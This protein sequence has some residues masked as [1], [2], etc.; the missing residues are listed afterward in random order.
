MIV[1]R[2]DMMTSGLLIVAKTAEAYHHLQDQFTARTVKKKYLALVEGTPRSE[3]GVI[4]LP[5]SSDPMNRPLQI[6]IRRNTAF[7]VSISMLKPERSEK[8]QIPL[9]MPG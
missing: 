4:D 2:L 3:H 5:L 8:K 6:M 9:S 7:A 1:H